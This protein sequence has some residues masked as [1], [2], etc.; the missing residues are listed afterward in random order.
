MGIHTPVTNINTPADVLQ[1][2]QVILSTYGDR[3]SVKEKDKFLVK[4][5]KNPSVGSSVQHTV[6][7][8][9]GSETNETFVYDNLIDSFSTNNAS[10]VN[11]PFKIEGHT[12]ADTISVASITRSGNIATVTTA[13]AHGLRVNDGVIIAGADQ[14][15]YNYRARVLSVPSST[16][17]TMYAF[18]SPTTPA[19]GTITA[20][21]VHY[22]FQVQEII[23]NGQNA[24]AL[25]PTLATATR[26]YNNG[27]VE[28][29]ASS[30]GYIYDD[31][32]VTL[33]GGVPDQNDQVHLIVNQSDHQSL[34]GSTTISDEDYW[35]LTHLFASV[36]KKTSASVDIRLQ[37]QLPYGVWRSAHP[38]ITVST[39]ANNNIV[40]PLNNMVIVPR[41]SHFRLT[42]IASTTAVEVSGGCAGMLAKVIG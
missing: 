11:M 39:T 8:L 41:N 20:R 23:A 36:N 7:E 21:P 40:I 19:T 16:T 22:T 28:M 29:Q 14:T 4:W 27:S 5:G 9:A 13:S 35:I 32:G 18:G 12:I 26:S 38:P 31:T 2:E 25:D 33:T 3:V 34:K 6:M 30:I 37:V 15:E 10:N 42:A 1:A 24:V 17:F